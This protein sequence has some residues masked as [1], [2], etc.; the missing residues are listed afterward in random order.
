MSEAGGRLH[1]SLDV[2]FL[3]P[4]IAPAV[5]T[6][7]PGGATFREAH[8]IMEMLHDSGLVTSLDLAE[9]NPSLDERERTARLM[10]DLAVSLVRTPGPRSRHTALLNPTAPS[11]ASRGA[12]DLHER[13][14][15]WTLVSRAQARSPS[16]TPPS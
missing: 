3:D 14:K 10:T 15:T 5:S 4:D 16:G 1:V 7:I 13:G 9:L 2:D 6:T 12:N 8:L 11:A